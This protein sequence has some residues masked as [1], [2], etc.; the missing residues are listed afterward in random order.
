MPIDFAT[1]GLIEFARAALPGVDQ[2]Y[3][4]EARQMQALSLA[5]HIP[6]VCFGVAFPAMVLYMEGLY[7]RTGDPL[8]KVI[9]KR[10][11][12]VMLILF[13]VGAVT[14]TILSFEL[15]L[16]WPEF[17][18]RFG[19]VFGMAFALEG[20]AFFLEAIFIAIYVYG[21][22]RI[23]PRAHLL[24]GI[25][26]VIAGFTGS[27]MVI[28]VNGWMNDPGGFELDSDGNVTGVNP[29]AAFVNSN[30]WHEWVHMYLAG[31]LVAGFIVAGVYAFSW[32]R[33]HRDR[34]RQVAMV[35]PLTFA[36]LAAPIQVV[37]GDWAGRT[38]A[39]E[40]PT[41]LAA[42]EGLEQTTRG[43]DLRLG[44][45][46]IGD[47]IYGSVSIPDGLSL[48]A[49]HDPN[50][51]VEGL[52]AVPADERPPVPVVRNAFQVM[53]GIGT[54]LALLAVVYLVTA[55][56]RGRPP[57]SKWF[58]IA[59]VAAGP[60]AL[61]ALIA[62]WIVTEV[63]RQPWIVYRVMR[64]SEAVTGAEGIPVGY[65]TLA[66]VYA[67]L[68]VIVLYLLRRLAHRPIELEAESAARGVDDGSG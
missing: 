27:L 23:S 38:V 21:W 6:L 52:N 3:L 46:M 51:E 24:T 10:W 30:V 48:L 18:E 22:D 25:P 11:S 16:L 62:G 68:A 17:M 26:V 33:G 39:E 63:G 59:V 65:A 7:V 35:V 40:Q 12:K 54:G 61:V 15:G 36:C 56:R 4:F 49:H 20:V 60:A 45:I 64:V 9:A 28:G 53:I 5:V 31:F 37:V 50:A 14:G 8:Y 67:A 44:G 2:P 13:A 42:F 43:A 1:T 57:R 66:L 47:E 58:Y 19:E 29:F 32:L 55:V 41:K 34:F